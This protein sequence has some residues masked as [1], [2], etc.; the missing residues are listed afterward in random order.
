MQIKSI[1]TIISLLI[2]DLFSKNILSNYLKDKEISIIND[3]FKLKLSYN[4]GIAFSIPLTGKLLIII[5]IFTILFIIFI[6]IKETNQNLFLYWDMVIAG[7][8]GNLFERFFFG[9]VTDFISILNFPI[10][11]IADMLIFLGI[12][13]ILF[14]KIKYNEI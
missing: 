9:K 11:N 6:R 3:I 2:I 7:G 5:T 8:L 12:V 14:S 13:G 10:F 1:L 4:E